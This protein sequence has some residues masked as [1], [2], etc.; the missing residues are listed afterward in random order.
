MPICLPLRSQAPLKQEPGH[1]LGPRRGRPWVTNMR[2]RRKTVEMVLFEIS[3]SMKPYPPPCCFPYTGKL[4]PVLGFLS[5]R[6]ATRSPTIFRQPLETVRTPGP[7]VRAGCRRRRRSRARANVS[8]SVSFV[9]LQKNTKY[10][11]RV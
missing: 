1:G 11:F 5:H 2:G 6:N 8:L 4:K 7:S 10:K 3:N 9:R